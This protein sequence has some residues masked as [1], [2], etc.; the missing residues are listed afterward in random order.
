ML[1]SES[2]DAVLRKVAHVA[3]V[4]PDR[5]TELSYPDWMAERLR[6][7]LGDEADAAMSR[8]GAIV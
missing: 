3:M 7:E 1:V 6:A 4:W 2:V 8:A 5:A